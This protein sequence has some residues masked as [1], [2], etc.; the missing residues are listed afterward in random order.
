MTPAINVAKKKKI[1]HKVHQYSHDP[2]HDS[3]GQEAAEKLGID[4][5]VISADQR[6]FVA[7]GNKQ[8]N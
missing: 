5:Q 3:Y 7:S 8:P 1:F 6:T 2:S 4:V